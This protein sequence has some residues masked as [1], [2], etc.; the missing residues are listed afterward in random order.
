MRLAIIFFSITFRMIL[1]LKG[2]T[3]KGLWRGVNSTADNRSWGKN[4]ARKE[5]LTFTT[6]YPHFDPAQ[7]ERIIG[8]TKGEVSLPFLSDSQ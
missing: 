7:C 3:L 5:I 2:V 6:N 1:N 4:I 8:D